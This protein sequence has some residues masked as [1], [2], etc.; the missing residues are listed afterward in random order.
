MSVQKAYKFTAGDIFD[1]ISSLSSRHL[2]KHT[3]QKDV[4]S[5]QKH[6]S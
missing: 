5:R 3:S 4:G 2:H 6:S 1:V